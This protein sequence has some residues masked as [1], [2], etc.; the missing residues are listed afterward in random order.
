MSEGADEDEEI[1]EIPDDD[2]GIDYDN[3]PDPTEGTIETVEQADNNLP[4]DFD[5]APT[6]IIGAI[7]DLLA[8]ILGN[9]NN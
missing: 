4:D 5:P 9:C 3:P 2:E 1:D 6:T 7:L 8:D